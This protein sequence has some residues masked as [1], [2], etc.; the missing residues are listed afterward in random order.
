MDPR[1]NVRTTPHIIC[2]TMKLLLT[3]NGITNQ[4]TRSALEA[5]MGKPV[6]QAKVV[7]IPTAIYAMTDGGMYA[8]QSL[9]ELSKLGWQAVSILE[10]TAIPSMDKRHWLPLLERADAIMVGGGNTPYLSY[11]LYESGLAR[12]LPRLLETKTYI[13]ISAGSIVATKEMYVD[14]A[15]ASRGIYED[16]QY[17]DRAPRGA[18][19]NKTLQ[20]VDFTL[21]PHLNA[22]YFEHVA[23]KDMEQQAAQTDTPLYAID[24]ASA[25]IVNGDKTTVVSEGDWRLF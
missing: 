11:W 24:D 8:W 1:S 13:G 23:M 9:E 22:D 2:N 3:S 4:T 25:V 10:L 19:S 12:E 15:K 5:L 7:F 6:D 18:G 21:R 17:G 14:P 16:N 20:L